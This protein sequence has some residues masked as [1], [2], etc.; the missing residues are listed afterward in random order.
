MANEKVLSVGNVLTED[1]RRPE[2]ARRPRKRFA[3]NHPEKFVLTAQDEETVRVQPAQTDEFHG[4]LHPAPPFL[5]LEVAQQ[6]VK[7]RL[8]LGRKRLLWMHGSK[9][10]AKSISSAKSR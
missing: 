6:E 4:E 8:E 7:G 10:L 1:N 9:A 2:N 5:L 3:G